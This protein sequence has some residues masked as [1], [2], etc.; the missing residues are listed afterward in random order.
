M[1]NVHTLQIIFGH[2]LLTVGLLY[3]FLDSHRTWDTPLRRL[4]LEGCSL[5]GVDPTFITSSNQLAHLKSLRLRRLRLTSDPQAEGNFAFGR[6]ASKKQ[7]SNGAGAYYRTYVNYGKL[8]AFGDRN[9]W[10]HQPLDLF[11]PIVRFDNAIYEK[12]PDAERL[13][14]GLLDYSFCADPFN[15]YFQTPESS[16]LV[17]Q[18]MQVAQGLCE[19]GLSSLT[20]LN[21][22]WIGWINQDSQDMSAHT[23]TLMQRDFLLRVASLRF[24]SLRSFQLRNAIS[25]RATT[26]I[27]TEVYLFAPSTH[28]GPVGF[29]EFMEAHPNLINLA[30]PMDRFY[31]HWKQDKNTKARL[32]VTVANLGRTLQGLR[33]DSDTDG[34][35]R[36]EPLTD[37]SRDT[38]SIQ[39]RARRRRFISD[40]APEMTKVKTIKMEGGVPRDEKR[41]IIRALHRSPLDKIVL[42]GISCPLG[43]L[44]GGDGEW[45][46][47]QDPFLS[48]NPGALEEEHTEAIIAASKTAPLRPDANFRFVPTYNWPPGAPLL[49]TIASHHG[50]TVKELKFCGYYGSPPLGLKTPLSDAMLSSLQYFDNLE[51]LVL[52][53]WLPTFFDGDYLDDLIIESW[54]ESRTA[55]NEEPAQQPTPLEAPVAELSAD[56]DGHS[57]PAP[58][59]HLS[60]HQLVVVESHPIGPHQESSPQAS[61][62]DGDGDTA[63]AEALRNPASSE[64][65]MSPWLH[66]LMHPPPD[67]LT[68]ITEQHTMRNDWPKQVKRSYNATTLAQQVCH[69]IGPHLSPQVK[70][71]LGGVRIRSSF[72]L[73]TLT[74]DIFDFDVQIGSVAVDG[75]M[76]DTV[77]SVKPPRE[78]MEPTRRREKLEAREWF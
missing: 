64:V 70:Q 59:Q 60:P 47:H 5:E 45:L 1:R 35:D 65:T 14:H 56:S 19:Q 20:S 33:V 53:V 69:M 34:F 74:S 77:L 29:L 43:N 49:H 25:T 6:G 39:A 54:V 51:A 73:G 12:L 67:E 32:G 21:L 75:K 11:V 62:M 18:P 37:E 61:T 57:L 8:E 31:P 40:F 58:V 28:A 7:L 72:C 22:D 3:N 52:S 30:W 48:D 17:K 68:L 16:C 78:E 38:H 55:P 10:Y 50:S 13:I 66:N 42:I 27:R 23:V 36:G 71:R 46:A 26:K 76:M 2:W 4:W 15:Q 9:K 63:M 41:E 44:W 24:R